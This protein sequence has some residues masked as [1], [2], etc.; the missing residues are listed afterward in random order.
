MYEDDL[1]HKILEGAF[2]KPL[3]RRWTN[4]VLNIISRHTYVVLFY[5]KNL[6]QFD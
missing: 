3:G 6:N 1:A 2:A 4:M 5:V